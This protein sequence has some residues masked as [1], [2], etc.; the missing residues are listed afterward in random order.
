M[1]ALEHPCCRKGGVGEW[2][3]RSWPPSS[4]ALLPCS[5][6]HG[7]VWTPRPQR[8]GSAPSAGLRWRLFVLQ[9]PHA[10][11]I[12]EPRQACGRSRPSLA[13][14]AASRA[15]APLTQSR[16]RPSSGSPSLDSPHPGGCCWHL[17]PDSSLMGD[18]HPRVHQYPKMTCPKLTDLFPHSLLS[19]PV[20][21][22]ATCPVSTL[23]TSPPPPSHSLGLSC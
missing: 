11:D 17:W 4:G 9:A 18:L 15:R 20:Y 5:Q 3:E 23:E 2:L 14:A 8:S 13:P 10:W 22:A 16:P 1:R 12:V 6:R 7:Q 21:G 19:L